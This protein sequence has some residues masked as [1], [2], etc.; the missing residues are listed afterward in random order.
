[1][2]DEGRKTKDEGSYM[3]GEKS[4]RQIT[5]RVLHL[6]PAEQTEVMFW[7]NTSALTRF[8]NNYVHQNVAEV[9]TNVNVR[10]VMGKKIG[11]A[12]TNDLSDEGL[13]KAVD[14]ACTIARFQMDNQDFQSLPSPE[15]ARAP[16]ATGSGFVEATASATP[17]MRAEGV[18]TICRLADENGLT[19]A[20]A[21][22]T[23]AQELAVANSLGVF[24]YDTLTTA[25]LLT[26][27]MG[28]N[29]SGYAD[30]TSKH[31]GDIDAEA[32]AR[33]AVGKA[34]RSKD[35]IEVEPGE[36]TVVLEEYAMGDMLQYLAFMGLSAQAVQ[37]GRSFLKL[38]EKITGDNISVYDDGSEPNGLLVAID[39]EG[40]AKQR[41]D[42]IRDGVAGSPVYDTYTGGKEGKRS[43]GHALPAP[44][45]WGPMPMNLYMQPGTTR[46]EDL[47]KGIERGIWVTR[48]HYTNIVHPLLTI[49]TGMTRDGTFLIEN[50]EITR[51]IKNLRFNQSVLEAWQ[52]AVLGDTLVLQKG[53]IGGAMVPAA[54]IERFKFASGTSF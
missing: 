39:F 32:V 4:I 37:E 45:V 27:I 21:F 40:V 15:E 26:V 36:Y 29:S 20:G 43:T 12:S 6:S 46:K 11:V 25:N 35:P 18:G 9:N 5:D 38:G 52:N 23:S 33:E 1:M 51:P 34:V 48:F 14:R 7:G 17:E 49:L 41:V 16:G 44:N 3:L 24:A 8:A 47:A 13:K 53:Y 31:V 50:G 28:E 42:L 54:R 2:T 19:A 22:S 30:R 10:V